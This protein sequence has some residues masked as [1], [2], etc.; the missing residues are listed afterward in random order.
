MKKSNGLLIALGLSPALAF[1]ELSVSSTKQKKLPRQSEIHRVLVDNNNFEKLESYYAQGTLP[2]QDQIAGYWSGRCYLKTSPSV[3]YGNVLM[4]KLLTAPTPP[5]PDDGPLFPPEEPKM[6]F[7]LAV[8]NHSGTFEVPNR[9]DNISDSDKAHVID[10]AKSA[11]FYKL[12]TTVV[13][14]SLLSVHDAGNL[15]FSARA[16]KDYYLVKATVLR[17]QDAL[18]AGDVFSMCYFFKRIID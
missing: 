7:N 15:S 18:Q 12:T 6:T 1:A 10:L 8:A 5:T 16:Y 4:A 13:D 2:S 3:A 17:N 9:Y 11:E 14:H